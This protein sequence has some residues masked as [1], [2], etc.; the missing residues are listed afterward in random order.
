MEWKCNGCGATYP[1]SVSFC[2][3]CKEI[4]TC[5]TCK[6]CGSYVSERTKIKEEGPTYV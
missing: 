3:Q 2:S 4:A 6:G 5:P 1:L